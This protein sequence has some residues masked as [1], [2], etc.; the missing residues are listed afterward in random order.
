MKRIIIAILIILLLF[1]GCALPDNA[2]SQNEEN[3]GYTSFGIWISYLELN[4]MLTSS[5]GFEAELA[6]VVK[7]CKDL[8]IGNV[9]IHVRPFCDS[10]FKSKYFPLREEVELLD[11]DVFEY[12]INTFHNEEIKVH[13]WINPYRVYT[14]S[15]DINA[16]STQSPVYKWLNDD[17]AENDKNVCLWNG[18]Y[19]NPAE[20]E[21][22]QLVI[23]GIREIIEIY[24]VD[25]IHFDDYFYPT[26]DSAF[27]EVSYGEYLSDNAKPVSLEDW[28]RT[29][30]NSLISGCNSAIKN[31]GKNIVFSISPAAA[32]DKNYDELYADVEY[33]VK[34][35][36]VD[37]VIPQLYFGF[38]YPLSEFRFEN[39]LKK[40]TKLMSSN[41]QVELIVGLAFYKTGTDVSPD[42]EEW[43]RD[44]D[45]I[46][47]QVKLCCDDSRING[48]SLYSYSS[49]F[50]EEVLNR[51]QLEKLTE[52]L[53]TENGYE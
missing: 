39:L 29:N 9:Y 14:A 31:S 44:T 46:A 1:C 26:T 22:Q 23:N 52:Y 5:N 51:S 50:S 6:D 41:N 18:I 53:T 4:A 2:A 7:N 30:V 8:G 19:L 38:E 34:N 16:L 48:F 45:I 12:I 13:A 15:S 32:I 27:D 35:N 24:D 10:V 25:G 42:S 17:S 40:W 11:Y 28:R 33:W 37:A 43:Q 49:V 47:R 36:M 3:S 20:T 21:V